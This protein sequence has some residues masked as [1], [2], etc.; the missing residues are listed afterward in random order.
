MCSLAFFAFLRIGEITIT[1]SHNQ[2]LQLLQIHQFSRIYD[3][4]NHVAG[5]KLT[6]QNFKYN[7]NQRP[8]TLEIY[9]QNTA[10]PVQLIL[11]YLVFCAELS[12][13]LFLFH[14]WLLQYCVTNSPLNSKYKIS[15]PQNIS[16]IPFG[17][18]QLPTLQKMVILMRKSV[19]WGVGN[20]TRF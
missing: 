11:D 10:C 7:Y 12:R 9:R 8:F 13:G 20:R 6:F 1:S 18:V 16:H 5:L 2:P 3:T 17:L 4:N 19:R 14:T 15:I